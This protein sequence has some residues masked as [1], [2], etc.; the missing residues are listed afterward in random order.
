MLFVDAGN[1]RIAIGSTGSTGDLHVLQNGTTAADGICLEKS[2]G[3]KWQNSVSS[4]ENLYWYYNGSY[5]AYLDEVSVVGALDFTGQHRSDSAEALKDASNVG[6]IVSST[7]VLSNLETGAL[8]T[9]NES[10]PIVELSAADNDKRVYGVIS[11]VEDPNA[12]Q[13]EYATGAWVSVYEK[14]DNRL[15]INA[16]GEGAVWVID[17]D[18]PL[19]NGDYITTCTI[20]GY[21]VPQADDLLHNYTVAKIT[22]DCSFDLSSTGYTCEEITIDGVTYLRALVACT[23]HCG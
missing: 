19:E 4:N 17:K 20:P 6:L 7:G 11:D 13:R 23:Y 21:G 16:L 1:N 9:I 22:Q 2:D 10:L 18:G 15:I 5:R 8:A 12:D 3:N 14:A